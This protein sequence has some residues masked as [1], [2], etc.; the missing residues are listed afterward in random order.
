M[1]ASCTAASKSELR[2]ADPYGMTGECRATSA[3]SSGRL[4]AAEVT[5]LRGA[6]GESDS[7]QKCYNP[8]TRSLR[9]RAMPVPSAHKP[10]LFLLT[11]LTSVT[12][13]H[14]RPH[15]QEP[16]NPL[17]RVGL[18]RQLSGVMR[19]TITVPYGA[20]VSGA[21]G[22]EVAKGPGV[23]LVEPASSLD[24][25]LL[26][27]TKPEPVAQDTELI[28]T[29]PDEGTP[30]ILTAPGLRKPL[31]YRGGLDIRQSKGGGLQVVNTVT[32]ES[33]LRGVIAAEMSSNAA[34]EALRAQATVSRTYALKEREM[35]RYL[36][37]GYDVTDTTACQVYGG[38]GAE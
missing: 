9:F 18:V 8:T 29:S 28:V 16:V 26:D 19:V 38:V 30:L 32:L 17:L 27:P 15:R 23:W 1:I 10:A 2:Q 13:A 36:P 4:A 35:G 6:R 25:A 21:S 24:V 34:I 37:A 7:K 20:T 31:R 12:T 33:Y 14:S 3:N 5:L 22:D 11:L